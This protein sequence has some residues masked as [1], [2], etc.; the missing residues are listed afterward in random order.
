M[1]SARRAS[2]SGTTAIENPVLLQRIVD[3]F[4]STVVVGIDARD[5]KVALRGWEKM[6]DLNALDLAE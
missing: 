5:G 6:S 4:G 2:S 3:E 1:T